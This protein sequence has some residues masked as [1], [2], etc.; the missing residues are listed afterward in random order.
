MRGLNTFRQVEKTSLARAVWAQVVTPLRAKMN[1]AR[2]RR[3]S[4][5]PPN[6][7]S[8]FAPAFAEEIA[9]FDRMR[10]EQY[11]PFGS[12][13]RDTITQRME[14]LLPDI[15]PVGAM[16]SERGAG[17]GVDV[18]DPTADVRL[19]EFCLAVPDAQYVHGGWDR[20]LM[21]RSMEGLLPPAVRWNRRRGLQGADLPFRFRADRRAC[22]AALEE[23]ASSPMVR[24]YMN[25]DVMR[26]MWSSVMETN[27]ATM[28][29]TSF[30]F[31][32]ALLIAL[33]LAREPFEEP[34]PTLSSRA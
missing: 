28:L 8:L 33:F 27:D 9:V 16:W 5:R 26:K 14:V 15:N 11:D 10:A 19:L 17:Y 24:R 25:V 7:G 23:I 31:A 32:R 6:D 18:R 12:A 4:I 13:T 2:F 34:S 30:F 1:S 20:A 3:G 22:D 21:R 29:Y